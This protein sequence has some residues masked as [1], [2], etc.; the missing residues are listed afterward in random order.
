[1]GQNSE[2]PFQKILFVFLALVVWSGWEIS[3][4]S[5]ASGFQ[6]TISSGQWMKTHSSNFPVPTL[7]E[8]QDNR[9][10]IWMVSHKKSNKTSKQIREA[11]KKDKE[12]ERAQRKSTRESKKLLKES[13]KKK[14]KSFLSRRA[15]ATTSKKTMKEVK[16]KTEIAVQNDSVRKTDTREPAKDRSNFDNSNNGSDDISVSKTEKVA[17]TEKVAKTE[18][19]PQSSDNAGNTTPLS[20]VASVRLTWIPNTESDLK[21]YEVYVGTKPGMYDERPPTFVGLLTQYDVENLSAGNTYYF[22]LK[23]IDHSGNKSQ[24]ASE[25][26]TSIF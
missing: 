20:Q 18:I 26:S 1:M 21:G 6:S 3:Q 16:P 22:S 13:L 19:K 15:K 14:R 2:F 11:K 5:G 17:E 4:P 8:K 12:K 24:F 25:V 10:V 9:G 7:L 23:A